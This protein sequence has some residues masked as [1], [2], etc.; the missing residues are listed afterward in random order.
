MHQGLHFHVLHMFDMLISHVQPSEMHME[1]MHMK[2]V[3]LMKN[4]YFQGS[5]VR[6]LFK[7]EFFFS[8]HIFTTIYITVIIFLLLNIYSAVQIYEFIYSLS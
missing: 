1:S 7:P 5:W 8:G 6:I 3:M 4:V 2:N